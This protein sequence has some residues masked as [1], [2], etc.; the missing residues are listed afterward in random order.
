LS[1]VAFVFLVKE[2]YILRSLRVVRK[3]QKKCPVFIPVAIWAVNIQEKKIF[4]FL[5]PVVKCNREAYTK[6][7]TPNSKIVYFSAFELPPQLLVSK[8]QT[9]ELASH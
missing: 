3:P 7:S 9:G 6:T 2:T 5:P 4:C 8:P 1:K